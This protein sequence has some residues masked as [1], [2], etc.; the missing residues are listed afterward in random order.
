MSGDGEPVVT[1]TQV[2]VRGVHGYDVSKISYI[3]KDC[4]KI[5]SF[6]SRKYGHLAK[7]LDLSFNLLRTL[8]GLEGFSC[9]EELIL[10][11]NQLDDHVSFPPLPKLHTLTVNKNQLTDLESL[12]DTLASVAP[13]LEYLSLLGNQACPNELVS[14]EKDED[15]YQRYRYFVLNKLPNLKFLDARKVTRKEQEVAVS[16]GAF[17]KIVKPKEIQ[18]PSGA[19]YSSPDLTYTPLPSLSRDPTNHRGVLGK[20]RY[21]YYG[22]HSEGNRFIRD[23]EL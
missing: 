11:N 19:E 3:G 2:S 9:L 1:D 12:L 17:M 7:R 8:D 10:D 14:P 15:D 13:V 23:D 20:C 16:R 6:L 21:I 4:T 22:K 5:P 18:V